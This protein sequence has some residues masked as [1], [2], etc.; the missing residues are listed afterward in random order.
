MIYTSQSGEISI[1]GSRLDIIRKW[2]GLAYGAERE[3]DKIQATIYRQYAE[4]IWKHRG[5]N[6]LLKEPAQPESGE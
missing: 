6:D 1:K 5:L 2:E 3:G 4:D